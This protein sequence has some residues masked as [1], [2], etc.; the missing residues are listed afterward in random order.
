MDNWNTSHH[1]ASGLL[2]RVKNSSVDEVEAETLT[3]AFLENTFPP[4]NLPSAEIRFA[5]T[6]GFS[7]YMP[8]LNQFFIIAISTS[9]P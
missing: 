5:K 2:E 9:P 3:L 6:G 7:R 1:T 4:A 8:R